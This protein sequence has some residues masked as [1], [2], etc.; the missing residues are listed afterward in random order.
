MDLIEI[1]HFVDLFVNLAA[2]FI[3]FNESPLRTFSDSDFLQL[4]I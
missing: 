2:N 4:F 1:D 3:R